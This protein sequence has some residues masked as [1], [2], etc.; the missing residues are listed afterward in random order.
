MKLISYNEIKE[1]LEL[2]DR[3]I[4]AIENAFVSYSKGKC[5][6][7]GVAH[8]EVKENNGA[9]HIRSGYIKG[10]TFCM[11]KVASTFFDNPK[12]YDLPSISGLQMTFDIKTGEII[13][14]LDERAYITNV[15]TAAAGAVSAKHLA[16]KDADTVG[17]I[18]IGV[19]GRL[20]LAAAMKVSNAKHAF[21]YRRTKSELKSYVEEMRIVHPEWNVKAANSIEEVSRNADILITAT[22]SVSHLVK[23]EWLKPGALV[24]GMGAD[25]VQKLELHDDMFT[26]SADLVVADSR[27]QNITLAEIARGIRMGLFGEERIDAELGEI[28]TG[29]KPGRSSE[30]QIIVCKLTGVAV[31]D[32]AVCEIILKSVGLLPKG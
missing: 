30:S 8:L 19:Q 11:V 28:I 4:G 5:N 29:L 12:N 14:V 10:S 9:L 31:Q 20:Q 18:G 16:R 26:N 3:L 17:V 15:R 1:I 27:L 32:I 2:D 6:I 24:I 22:P 7:P 21:V 25:S 13:A 23:R